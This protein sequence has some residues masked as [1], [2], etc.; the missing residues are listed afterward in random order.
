MSSHRFDELHYFSATFDD[1][2]VLCEY[3]SAVA[4]EC[5]AVVKTKVLELPS[6]SI[7]RSNRLARLGYQIGY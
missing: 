2:R 4:S 6:L 5:I 1:P 3:L 7:N